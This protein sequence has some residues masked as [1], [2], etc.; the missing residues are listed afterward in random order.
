MSTQTKKIVL[1]CGNPDHESFTGSVL[2]TYE[3]AASEAGHEVAY[4][5]GQLKFDPIL[6]KG[7]KFK[8]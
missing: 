7:Y 5:L 1:I 8:H 3:S 6:H 2:D 4:N